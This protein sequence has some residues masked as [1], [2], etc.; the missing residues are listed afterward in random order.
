MNVNQSMGSAYRVTCC[1]EAGRGG[2]T[3]TPMVSHSLPME[4]PLRVMHVVL[5]MDVGG[6]ERI[7]LDLTREGQRLGQQVA[8]AC[9]ERPGTLAPHLEAAGA[10]VICVDKPPGTHP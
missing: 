1:A 3:G 4:T 6:L 2:M 5:S 8:V 7:V 9:L 10:R